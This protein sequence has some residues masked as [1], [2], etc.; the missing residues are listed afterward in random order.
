[1]LSIDTLY[2]AGN[3]IGESGASIIADSLKLN[4]FLTNLDLGSRVIY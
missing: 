2:F 3:N 4:I 1:V